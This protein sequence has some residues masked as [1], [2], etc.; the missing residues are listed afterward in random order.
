[1]DVRETMKS[2]S[3]DINTARELQMIQEAME[4]GRMDNPALDPSDYLP[5]EV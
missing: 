5:I 4:T 3:E 1:M 2:A